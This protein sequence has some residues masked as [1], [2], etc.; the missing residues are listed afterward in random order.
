M[1]IPASPIH[2]FHHPDRLAAALCVRCGRPICASCST[3]WEGMHHC[4]GCLA[5]RRAATRE[6]GAVARAVLLVVLTLGLAAVLTLVRAIAGAALAGL[7]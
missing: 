6:T 2:C 3:R 1:P 5:A 4:V 7:F